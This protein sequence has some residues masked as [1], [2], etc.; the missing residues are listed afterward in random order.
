LFLINFAGAEA[1]PG[2]R[3]VD[4]LIFLREYRLDAWRFKNFPAPAMRSDFNQR[5]LYPAAVRCIAWLGL[6]AFSCV[7]AAVKGS[8][9]VSADDVQNEVTSCS[10]RSYHPADPA[11]P[12]GKVRRAFQQQV[13]GREPPLEEVDDEA[14]GNQR[15]AD[16][17]DRVYCFRS[18]LG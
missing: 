10:E 9:G 7:E 8:Y 17:L 2:F 3:I 13:V 1:R 5:H 12:S 16:D 18:H 4:G 6:D 14:N 15:A 11:Q